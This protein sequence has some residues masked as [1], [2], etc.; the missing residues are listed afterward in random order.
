ERALRHS[1]AREQAATE[2]LLAALQRE[3]AA[4]ERLADAL[5]REQ[6]ATQHLREL[7]EMKDAFSRPSP[8]TCVPR[9]PRC[10]GSPRPWTEA[11]SSWRPARSVTCSA[12]WQP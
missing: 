1:L 3:H 9:S 12:G 8:M 2:R 6:T 10:G 7:D 5:E 11:T 4:A